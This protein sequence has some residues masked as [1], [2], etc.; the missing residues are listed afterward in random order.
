MKT[1]TLLTALVALLALAACQGRSEPP[2]E[3][4][5]AP[6]PEAPAKA[7]GAEPETAAAGGAAGCLVEPPPGPVACTMEWNPVCGCDGKT[8]G[9]ACQARAAGVSRHM[10]GECGKQGLR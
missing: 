4:S 7:A 5:G 1:A 8:Y 10:P 9:N 2:A 6:Q 3:A